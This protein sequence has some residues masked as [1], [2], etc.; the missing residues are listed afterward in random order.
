MTT[1]PI[2]IRLRN[3]ISPS[4]SVDKSKG[5]FR[6]KQSTGYE[7]EQ[8][9][10][11]VSKD[12]D[13][14]QS[15][16]ELDLSNELVEA[17]PYAKLTK[18]LKSELQ[19][20]LSEVITKLVKANRRTLALISQELKFRE[21]HVLTM[22]SCEWSADGKTWLPC[23]FGGIFFT[24][25]TMYTLHSLDEKTSL[26]IQSLLDR[27]EEPL[28]ATRHLQ[29]AMKFRGS[30]F[31]WLEASAAAELAIKEVLIRLEP[32]LKSIIYEIPSPPINKLYGIILESIVG[33]KSPYHKQL[34]KGSE[35]RNK[36]LHRPVE[37]SFEDGEVAAYVIVVEKA[38]DHL[39]GILRSRK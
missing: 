35:K 39:L 5:P 9:V 12:G 24:D 16:A 29:E 2:R 1:I 31:T 26:H 20:E 10:L 8:I 3:G 36:I 14:I 7:H 18:N 34:A 32:I 22:G 4:I 21:S 37:V 17:M 13:S 28:L 23:P 30:R 6:F 25:V 19:E 38:I 33:E 15:E 27:I 11:A